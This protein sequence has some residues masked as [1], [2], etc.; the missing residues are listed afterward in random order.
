MRQSWDNIDVN[1]VDLIAPMV[2]N[3]LFDLSEKIMERT[4]TRQGE[5]YEKITVHRPEK[6][7]SAGL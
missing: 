1:G 2:R 4:K 3:A 7:R 6:Y 5:A